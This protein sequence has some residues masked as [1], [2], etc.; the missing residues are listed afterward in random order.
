MHEVS[1]MQAALEIALEQTRV[2]G[3]SRVHRMTLRVGA[4]SG[5]VPDALRFAFDVVT[6]G[7]PAE[8]AELVIEELPLRC[9]CQTCGLSFGPPASSHDL[10][11]PNGPEHRTR[12]VSGQELDVGTLEIS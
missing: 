9:D 11:C 8:G 4:L 2:N 1:L 3:G 7:T 5:A 6:E 12:I 10:T